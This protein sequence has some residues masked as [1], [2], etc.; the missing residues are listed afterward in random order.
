[1][2]KKIPAVHPG[3][4]LREEYLSPMGL[5]ANEVAKAIG[6]P[7][8]RVERLVREETPLTADTAL[9]LS[10]YFGNPAAFWM[11]LQTQYDLE[12]V[13]DQIEQELKR[14]PRRAAW[15]RAATCT[16]SA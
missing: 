8:T 5:T 14:I 11:G 15:T 4:I 12:T 10:R 9:R 3:E 13:A 7:R 16:R 1:M 2:A 6:I